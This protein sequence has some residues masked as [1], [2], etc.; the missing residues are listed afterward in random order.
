MKGEIQKLR[1]DFLEYLLA[2]PSVEPNTRLPPSF[3]GQS[4]YS[5]SREETD[6]F[7]AARD[8]SRAILSILLDGIVNLQEIFVYFS[9]PL[10]LNGIA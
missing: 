9:P 6:S 3:S 1:S 2:L 8:K 4:N 7:K 10:D 5:N